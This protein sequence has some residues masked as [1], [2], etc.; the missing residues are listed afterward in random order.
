M[1]K[2]AGDTVVADACPLGAVT[3]PPKASPA[4]ALMAMTG[5]D[6]MMMPL[7]SVRDECVRVY[8]GSGQAPMGN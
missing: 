3:C 4:Q 6:R 1:V 8:H 2:N 7:Y 5:M